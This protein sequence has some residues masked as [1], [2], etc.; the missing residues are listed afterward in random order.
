MGEAVWLYM[1]CLD[2]MTSVDENGIGKVLGGSPIKY[3]QI[4]DDLGI[5]SHGYS[6]W[7]NRLKNLGYL[8]VKRTP[9]GLILSINK[10]YKEF[11]KRNKRYAR[12]AE[13]Y[14]RCAERYA[15]DED[16]IKTATGHVQDNTS[17]FKKINATDFLNRLKARAS[18]S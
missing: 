14:A 1:W 17:D 2:K 12:N 10:A 5:S 16:V 3:K 4:N 15:Q 7:V 9:Y 6:K 18:R 13:R 11:G 8:N